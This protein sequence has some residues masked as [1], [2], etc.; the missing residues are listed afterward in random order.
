MPAYPDHCPKYDM[1]SDTL[2]IIAAAAGFALGV[3]C[4][5]GIGISLFLK[6]RR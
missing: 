3:M 2:L 5:V 4:A 6:H 1:D